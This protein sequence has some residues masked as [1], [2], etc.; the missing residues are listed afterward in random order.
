MKKQFFFA[1]L[2]T[3]CILCAAASADPV[4][5][6]REATA[7]IAENNYLYLQNKCIQMLEAVQR[8][9]R[10]VLMKKV[11][12]NTLGS[13]LLYYHPNEH[14]VTLQDS[15]HNNRKNFDGRRLYIYL[16]FHILECC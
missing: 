11:H 14:L 12:H 16:C 2:M 5:T 8:R 7:W 15:T 9:F 13:L 10:I 3:L 1:V 4:I 6:D